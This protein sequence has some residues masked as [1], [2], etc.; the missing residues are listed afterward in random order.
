MGSIEQI[1]ARLGLGPAPL[2]QE[3]EVCV[4]TPADA[5]GLRLP[6]LSRF[7][8]ST[9]VQHLERNPGMALW[10]PDAGEYIVSEP[11][12]NRQDIAS[13]IEV[14]AR[15]HKTLLVRSLIERL[16]EDRYRLALLANEVWQD[17]TRLYMDMD[18]GEI[19]SIVFFELTLERGKH[20]AVPEWALPLPELRYVPVEHSDLEPLLAVDHDSFPWLWWNS[21]AEME[22]YLQ[23]RGVYAYLA[24]CDGEPV[25]YASFTLYKG[26]AHLDRLAVVHRHQGRKFGA[27]QLVHALR[28]MANQ[29]ASSVALSTQVTNVQS[30]RLYKGF[31]FHQTNE[32]MHF[33]GKVIHET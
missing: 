10:V 2:S 4:L 33:Y 11:W 17:Q 18:F 13:I 1:R 14:T 19:E 6:W 8:P 16:A 15:R 7:S 30:H 5:R 27:A 21:R 26:W 9:I 28:L 3:A 22:T 32:K 23:M 20:I 25:G 29:G 12:R 31:G 24:Y